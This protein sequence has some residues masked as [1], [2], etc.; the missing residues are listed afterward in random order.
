MQR[1]ADEWKQISIIR[2]ELVNQLVVRIADY[3]FCPWVLSGAGFVSVDRA[4]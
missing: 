1:I 4:E 2:L 3:L